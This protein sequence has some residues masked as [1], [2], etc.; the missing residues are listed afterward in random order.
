MTI[1]PGKSEGFDVEIST[2]TE[3]LYDVRL[4][5][6][7][8]PAGKGFDAALDSTRVRIAFFDRDA[9]YMVDRG[10]GTMLTYDDYSAEM[11]T[12]GQGLEDY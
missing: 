2:R 1:P 7:G 9:G 6:H 11:K 12:W 4:R 5:V 3:G 10:G 8:G